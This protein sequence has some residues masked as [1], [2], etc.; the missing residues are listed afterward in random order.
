MLSHTHKSTVA[1]LIFEQKD[2]IN[3]MVNEKAPYCEYIVVVYVQYILSI[4][5]S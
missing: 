2:E 3:V 4:P 1:F 5:N